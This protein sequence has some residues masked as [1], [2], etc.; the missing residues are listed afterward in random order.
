MT[1]SEELTVMIR[2]WM[3]VSTTRSMH[4]WTRYVKAS[5]LSMPQFGI[6]MNLYYRQTCGISDI[7][8]HMDISPGAASQLVEKLVQSGLLD[9]TEDPND[10]RAKVLTLSSRGRAM[11]ESGIESR[12]QWADE[13]VTALTL[14]E[15]EVVATAL[16]ALTRAANRIETKKADRLV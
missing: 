14:A 1:N 10:R 2:Q 11:I 16:G 9:R 7:G 4:A 15:F 8:E 6:L 3:D 5:G 13:L 12:S